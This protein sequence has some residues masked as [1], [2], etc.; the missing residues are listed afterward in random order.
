MSVSIHRHASLLLFV[1]LTLLS[2]VACGQKPQEKILGRWQEVSSEKGVFE[3]FQDQTWLCRIK[4]FLDL[5][6]VDFIEVN[7]PKFA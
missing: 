7:L 1:L 6:R 5:K 4:Q 2:V 3:F